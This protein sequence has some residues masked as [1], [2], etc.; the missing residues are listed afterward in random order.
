MHR[1]GFVDKLITELP[2]MLSETDR[3]LLSEWM[4]Q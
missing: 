3:Q 1:L 2:H 4:L